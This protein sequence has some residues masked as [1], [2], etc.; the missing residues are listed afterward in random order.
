MHK[1]PQRPQPTQKSELTKKKVVVIPVC[2]PTH[3]SAHSPKESWPQ[4]KESSLAPVS[5]EKVT[6]MVGGKK[7]AEKKGGEKEIRSKVFS[8]QQR[9]PSKK[10]EKGGKSS[11]EVSGG[12]P[13]SLVMLPVDKTNAI[14]S[15]G[16]SKNERTA[17]L[18]PAQVPVGGVLPTMGTGADKEYTVQELEARRRVREQK[19]DDA[20][21]RWRERQKEKEV[22]SKKEQS[23]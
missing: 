15:E 14:Q 2:E 21:T 13:K 9:P 3:P 1:R 11:E 20:L 6:A 12:T 23:S 10:V 5:S 7:E 8:K 17:P 22:P 4:S 16:V 18:S 19:E